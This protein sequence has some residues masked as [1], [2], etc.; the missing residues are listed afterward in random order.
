MAQTALTIAVVEDEQAYAQTLHAYILRYAREHSMQISIMHYYDGASFIDEE[1]F[2]ASRN[3]RA[4]DGLSRGAVTTY[5]SVICG[6]LD[7]FASFGTFSGSRI[8]TDYLRDHLQS[9]AFASFPIDCLYAAT[10]NFDFAMPQQLMDYHAMLDVEPRLEKGVNTVFDI[11][12]M[13]YHSMGNWHLAL[14]N[15]LQHIF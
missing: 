5:R 15:F 12:P 13:R 4:F 14:Y 11:F 2:T 1:G 3:H 9:G 10:G 7:Y 8:S 6:C